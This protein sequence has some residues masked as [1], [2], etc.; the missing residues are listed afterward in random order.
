MTG[1]LSVGSILAAGV[2]LC[3]QSAAQ[4][5]VDPL[6][7]ARVLAENGKFADSEDLTRDYLKSNP[8]SADGHFVLGYILFR[9][10]KAR[11]SLVEFTEGA[12]FRHPSA[13]DFRIVAS[14]YVLLGDY[15]D[16]VKWFTQFTAEKPDDPVGWYLLG[17]ARYNEDRFNEAIADFQ[18]ALKLRSDYV[19]AEN[20][21]GL[22]WQGLND[23]DRAKG[24]FEAAIEWQGEHPTDAQPYL[25]LGSLLLQQGQATEAVPQLQVAA[26]LAEKNPKIHEVLGRAYE[27]L[28]DLPHAREE[29]EEA[30]R[31]APKV[32]AL[33]FKLG[34]IYRR[35]GLRDQAQQQ[36]GICEKLDS[37]HSSGETP[38]PYSLE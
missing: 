15:T 23:L 6:A 8:S 5:N 3:M 29:L 34:R 30:V 24:A 21:L 17:R 11:E 4:Q 33:H 28:N 32:S 20:N 2:F 12:R 25:N 37:T 7:R 13:D 26:R 19:E 22:A 27:V 1:C 18:H 35:E 14:D 9:E 16:A 31:I 10:H 36:F 38:N